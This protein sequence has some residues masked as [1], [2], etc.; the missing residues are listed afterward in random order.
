MS[1]NAGETES[2]ER[3]FPDKKYRI[4]IM[5]RTQIDLVLREFDIA[6]KHYLYT[7]N[8]TLK[9]F[10]EVCTSF[11]EFVSILSS[12]EYQFV[13]VSKVYRID[14]K[15]PKTS[16]DNIMMSDIMESRYIL[17]FH[18]FWRYFTRMSDR[19]VGVTAFVGDDVGPEDVAT[20]C[21][22]A[23]VTCDN[24]SHVA[25]DDENET[26]S[27]QLHEDYDELFDGDTPQAE[28]FRSH[29]K[30][31]PLLTFYR[32]DFEEKFKKDMEQDLEHP[33]PCINESNSQT[34]VMD[35]VAVSQ[36]D[37]VS[38]VVT[39]MKHV[40]AVVF[41]NF[42]DETCTPVLKVEN[43]TKS[44][45]KWKSHYVSSDQGLE[46]YGL[47]NKVQET[48]K[49]FAPKGNFPTLA[50]ARAMQ[51]KS[52]Y[53]HSRDDLIN[54]QAM[55]DKAVQFTENPQDDS[56]YYKW[57]SDMM[58]DFNQVHTV[59]Y[60]G[61][62]EYCYRKYI[63]LN[64]D[65]NNDI[66]KYVED[67]M[68]LTLK[69]EVPGLILDYIERFGGL[70]HDNSHFEK[71]FVTPPI[72][73]SAAL[74]YLYCTFFLTTLM[75]KSKDKNVYEAVVRNKKRGYGTASYKC[76]IKLMDILFKNVF[77]TDLTKRAYFV[78]STDKADRETMVDTGRK[79]FLYSIVCQFYEYKVDIDQWDGVSAVWHSK[80]RTSTSKNT[81]KAK[82][83][84]KKTK[85]K[86]KN[87]KV[88]PTGTRNGEGGNDNVKDT[89][90]PS[91]NAGGSEGNVADAL[92]RSEAD[93]EEPTSTD[94]P[95]TNSSVRE[96]K[97]DTS[98]NP[99]AACGVEEE[100]N[101]GME[102]TLLHGSAVDQKGN[103]EGGNDKRTDAFYPSVNGGSEGNDGDV[104]TTSEA[105]KEK[106]TP[107]HEK[108]GIS[109]GECGEMTYK[110]TGNPQQEF[111]QYHDVDDQHVGDMAFSGHG[112]DT[113]DYDDEEEDIQEGD[114]TLNKDFITDNLDTI[115][116]DTKLKLSNAIKDNDSLITKAHDL[117]SNVLHVLKELKEQDC[118]KYL[119]GRNCENVSVLIEFDYAHFISTMLM[120]KAEEVIHCN[121]TFFD[122]GSGRG[123]PCYIMSYLLNIPSFGVEN[124]PIYCMQSLM[125]RCALD[126]MAVDE[127]KTSTHF[128]QIH[129]HFEHFDIMSLKTLGEFN[130]IFMASLG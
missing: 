100:V 14:A 78:E 52:K 21:S 26:N 12:S 126:E 69:V 87:T 120:L 59:V 51:L 115:M 40:T 81:K 74:S 1:D 18:S 8:L 39:F 128:K 47:D 108:N 32:K 91:V 73:A 84:K 62:R 129:C 11:T 27:V 22:E 97:A 38:R 13:W 127:N 102:H 7:E 44:E 30:S 64:V 6:W 80:V 25:S 35:G 92:N 125:G 15:K 37:N 60:E 41:G 31:S 36:C 88:S 55:L 42:K 119:P 122:L 105:D 86:T 3:W 58:N 130:F 111:F 24:E 70:F 17:L 28:V 110:M 66:A 61:L 33:R 113:E 124:S 89:C 106:L 43:Y 5:R 19:V 79:D 9:S 99:Q 4:G 29:L 53:F 46:M 103:A 107:A 2:Q 71:K 50:D 75:T 118:S 49:Y 23:S 123:W 83:N 72:H 104:H 34:D 63:S 48:N 101:D 94:N 77:F 114:D 68:T 82:L 98:S 54:F 96:A 90:N 76:S 20:G 56:S 116:R 57:S 117:K 67:L 85:K 10:A 112:S 93:K 45:Q 95:P 16:D 65:R 121:T 109:I